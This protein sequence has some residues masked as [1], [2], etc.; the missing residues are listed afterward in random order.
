MYTP[1]QFEMNDPAELTAFMQHYN[2]AALV[3]HDESG[4]TATHLPFMI[5][6]TRGEHGTLIAHLARPNPQWKSFANGQEALVM[7][8]GPH[9]YVSPRW[10]EKPTINVPTWNYT[11]VHAYGV[12]RVVE[13][14]E[15][16]Y[17]MLDQ[18]VLTHEG[19]YEQPWPMQSAEEHV[20]RLIGGIVGFEMMI[21]RVE[22]KAKLSQNR[23]EADRYHVEQKLAQSADTLV[24]STAALMQMRREK[25]TSETP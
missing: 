6:S 24:S 17:A 7:F 23:S 21:T 25:S 20:R 16:I 4:L 18:L 13:D 22:G 3:T 12:P 10:Y 1:K 14:P 11:A 9:A 15:E 19:G 8:T 2:F 5:D